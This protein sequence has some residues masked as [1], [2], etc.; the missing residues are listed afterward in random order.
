MSRRILAAKIVSLIVLVIVGAMLTG[1]D[2]PAFESNDYTAGYL[3]SQTLG[4][5]MSNL[6]GRSKDSAATGILSGMIVVDQIGQADL[7]QEEGMKAYQEGND[8]VAAEA[9]DAAIE[10]RP[11]DIEYRRDRALI[12]ISQQD[13]ETAQANWKKQDEIVANNKWADD[14]WY[15]AEVLAETEHV[16]DVAITEGPNDDSKDLMMAA[17]YNRASSVYAGAAKFA[18]AQGDAKLA[19]EYLD[20]ED[21]YQ[22][23]ARDITWS[24]E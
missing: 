10:I 1:C 4:V 22:S 18:E 5:Q 15:W 3:A 21:A 24:D 7:R 19:E 2:G 13:V 9:L 14:A 16:I 11:E 6:S 23:A 12:A 20:A 8:T 17:A